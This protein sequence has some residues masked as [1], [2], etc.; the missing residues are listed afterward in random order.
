M[1]LDIT[2]YKIVSKNTKGKNNFDYFSLIDDDGNYLNNFPEWTKKLE[3]K[4]TETWY[5]WDKYKEDT[6]IDVRACRWLGESYGEEGCVMKLWDS[7]FGEYPEI[8]NF[9]IGED[10][11]GPKFDWETYYR[12]KEEHT[13]TIDLK[14][15]PT[16]KKQ[17][18]ILWKEEVGYQRKG[19]NKQFY[20]DYKDGKIGYFVWNKADLERYK[21]DYCV[22]DEIK[23]HFQKYVIDPFIDG[24]C[25]ATFSW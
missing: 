4:K 12:L 1:G 8:E 13:I 21:E 22:D 18:K 24:Q 2:V 3:R 7:N 14:K 9:K 23:E 10:E 19:F 11:N 17:I 16:Y 20:D 25:C 15:V 6:G 5:D